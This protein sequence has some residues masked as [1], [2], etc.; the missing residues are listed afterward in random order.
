M[1]YCIWMRERRN[2]CGIV[3]VMIHDGRWMHKQEEK[4]E[5]TSE[6]KES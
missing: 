3:R 5:E 2:R 4:R 6:K 1:V